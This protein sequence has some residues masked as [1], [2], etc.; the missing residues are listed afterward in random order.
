LETSSRG[1]LYG[2]IDNSEGSCFMS[3]IRNR[4]FHNAKQVV[5]SSNL[6]DDIY[7]EPKLIFK[8]CLTR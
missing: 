6:I 8:R 1:L 4:P 5:C 2:V 7:R 3:D